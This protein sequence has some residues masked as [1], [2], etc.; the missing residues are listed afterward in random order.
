[1]SE[2]GRAKRNYRKIL[3]QRDRDYARS[4]VA[5]FSRDDRAQ[6][7]SEWDAQAEPLRL[8]CE[9]WRSA[10]WVRKAR[11]C[12]VEL[13]PREPDQGFW[14]TSP[15]YG[16]HVLTD[17]GVAHVR[18]AVRGEILAGAEIWFR[19]AVV[20]IP[21]LSVILSGVVAGVSVFG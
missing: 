19:I 2:L 8:W 5:R 14:E 7:F 13:L 17:K 10:H 6:W 4:G 12:L 16:R 11:E 21:L 1:M 9:R 3:K 15:F 18:A 20:V